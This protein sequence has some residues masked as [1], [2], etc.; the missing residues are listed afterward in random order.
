[1]EIYLVGG[2]VRDALLGLSGSDRD[3]VVVGATPAQML[4]QGFVPVG[5][6]FPVF[7]HPESREEHALART[8]RKTGMGYKG[9]VVHSSSEVTLEQDL[10][11]RDLTI[12]AMAQDA[13]GRLI[14]PYGGQ[15]DLA[16]KVLRHVTEAF[17]EDPVRILRLARFAARFGDFHVASETLALC[18]EMVALGE[19]DALVPERVWQE[20]ER[21]LMTSHPMRMAQVLVEC[22]AWTRLWPEIKPPNVGRD[23]PWTAL[24]FWEQA[25]LA[26]RWALWLSG[27]SATHVQQINERLRVPAAVADIAWAWAEYRPLLMQRSANAEQ[28]TDLLHRLDVQRRPQRASELIELAFRSGVTIQAIEAAQNW[29]QALQAVL[30][31]DAKAVTQ[32]ALAQGLSGPA[33]GQALLEAH[34]QAIAQSRQALS[35]PNNASPQP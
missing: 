34:T 19:V 26:C 29:R 30:A 9:F 1:M 21:G 15:A 10:A 32:K 27:T 5:R 25:S 35:L 11:R 31:V 8:E 3:W 6:D 14:D 28:A 18:R 16:R 7:L 12:N 24:R 33:L 22:G 2:A 4:A 13:H 20:L 23:P 17:R